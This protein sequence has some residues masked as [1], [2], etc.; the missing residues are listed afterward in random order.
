MPRFE[1]MMNSFAFDQGAGKDCAKDWRTDA[2]FETLLSSTR[3]RYPA[4]QTRRPSA[5][6]SRNLFRRPDRTQRNS[7]SARSV[8]SAELERRR[9]VAARFNPR[10]SETAL[11]EILAR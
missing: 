5:N 2:W 3:S 10:R 8:A 11:E 1:Q 6:L 7:S 9:I 4:F